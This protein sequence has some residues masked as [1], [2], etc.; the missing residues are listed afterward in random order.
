M[1]TLYN[2]DS[3]TISLATG[4]SLSVVSTNGTYSALGAG[5]S[6]MGTA[7]A[8]ASGGDE[9]YGPYAAPTRIKITSGQLSQID[10]ASGVSPEVIA[11][12]P[13]SGAIV[14]TSAT[15]SRNLLGSDVE[16]RIDATS[17]SPIVL[18]IQT[19]A[20][21]GTSGAETFAIYQGGTG[22]ASF[23]AGAGV[24]LRNTAPTP[25][26]NKTHGVMRVGANEWAYIV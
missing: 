23:A 25:A 20:I 14:N 4:E 2:G 12:R 3:V 11:A 18:T 5:G 16:T 24:T 1:P 6:V 8:T 26:Q 19:D 21:M 17:A 15:A 10:Y 22:A 7:L 9:I 13:A